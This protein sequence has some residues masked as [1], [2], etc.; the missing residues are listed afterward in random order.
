MSKMPREHK[1]KNVAVV[2]PNQLFKDHPALKICDL[3]ILVE[4]P[5]FFRQYP[6]HKQK[7]AFHRA[8]MKAYAAYLQQREKEVVYLDSEQIK[9]SIDLI[10]FIPSSANGIYCV[11]VD[12]NYL[13]KALKELKKIFLTKSAEAEFKILNSPSFFSTLSEAR[14]LCGNKNRFFMASFY[15]AQRRKHNILMEGNSPRGG[16]WSFDSEN[17]KRLPKGQKAPKLLK[18]DNNSF[19]LEAIKYVEKNF[20]SNPGSLKYFI[21]PSTFNEAAD[22]LEDFL[23]N[24][25]RNY[26]DY[27]DAIVSDQAFLYH[28]LL[29]PLLNSGILTP[30]E[31][32]KK[33]VSFAEDKQLP[34]NTLEGLVRQLLGWR[35]YVRLVYHELGSRQRT[36]NFWG[37]TKQ[38]PASFWSAETGIVP[39]DAAIGRV[40]DFWLLPPY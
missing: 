1:Y 11:E 31:V 26:G 21:Y 39:L 35:E 16:K 8:S 33:A 2:Y 17:R 19:V 23:L 12:D 24:R 10:N 5:L 34:L 37:H 25:F 29:S 6:F 14:E 30:A 9:K 7:L 15:Q 36:R 20:S 3:F 4:D 13:S 27:Q 32:L 28:S 40:I 22:W 18:F 38:I